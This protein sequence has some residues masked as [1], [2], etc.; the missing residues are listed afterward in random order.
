MLLIIVNTTLLNNSA[1]VNY[2]KKRYLF[3]IMLVCF[4]VISAVSAEKM[5][6]DTNSQDSSLSESVIEDVLYDGGSADNGTFSD[7]QKKIDGADEGSTILLENNYTYDFGF[8][9]DGVSINKTLTIN[10]NGYVIDALGQ[11]RIFNVNSASVTLNDIVFKN[12]NST[13]GGAVF[14]NSDNGIINNCNFTNSIATLM[15]G[16]IFWYGANGTVNNS[17]FI[18]NTAAKYSG[19]A[20]QWD[21]S[22]DNGTV[23]NC[24]FINN[25]ATQRGGAVY[26][27]RINGT[28][29]NSIFINSTSI[30][31]G[32]VNWSPNAFN[33][34]LNNS[35]FINNT[36]DDGG[37]IYWEGQNGRMN[38]CYFTN[39]TGTNGGA[40]NWQKRYGLINNCNFTGN[41]ATQ[42]G[43]AIFW[44]GTN[45]TVN[46][47]NFTN[48]GANNG[49]AVYWYAY[50]G[51]L[52]SSN[53]ANNTATQNG[54]AINWQGINGT[55]SICNFAGNTAQSN[56][57]A[58]SLDTVSAIS[59]DGL[60]SNIANYNIINSAFVDNIAFGAGSAVYR[61]GNSSVSIND[62]WW[63]SNS[64]DWN[65]L[66]GDSI[67][68][69]SSFAVL[70]AAANPQEI[71]TNTKSDLDYILYLNGTDGV[72]LIPTREI[73]LSST[74]G[75][76]DNTSG[77]LIGSEFS[78]EFT[79]DTSGVYEIIA[80]VDNEEIKIRIN[81]SEAPKKD[82][83]ITAIAEPVA[84][85]EN[86]T[87]IVTGFENATGNV[88]A[89]I[90]GGTCYAP[91]VD[92]TATFT[93]SDVTS[94]TTAYIIYEG[95][96]N[97]NPANTM[98]D[99]TVIPKS[100]VNIVADNLT[101]YY[102]GP[103][104]F[105]ANVY[106]CELNPI[107][108]KSVNITINGVTY[109]KITDSNGTAYLNIRLGSGT[110]D[111]TVKVDNTTVKSS[112]TVLST[113]IGGDITKYYKNATQYAVQV[114]DTTG[115]A[116]G[117]GEVVT[118]NVNGVFYNRTTDANGIAAL[119][120]NLPPGDYVITAD[121]K[122]CKVSNNITVLPVLKAEDLKMKYMDGSQFKV[123]LVDGQGNPYA[124][125]YVKFNVNGKLYDKLTDG[126]G[127]TALNIRLPSGEYIIT[128]SYNGANIANRI[129]IT[130]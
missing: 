60:I 127:Q 101:K 90:D 30:S 114:Y 16:A 37:A 27:E 65:D 49:G 94:N 48:N 10:G 87:I 67:A 24:I 85:G 95:D 103:E 88:T 128:S 119:N 118:F 26:W 58:I 97:Y 23:D 6:N 102:G 112:V 70:N 99:I 83:N 8:S 57:G 68:S 46:S 13:K 121:Y 69:P 86:I 53:F 116:S 73:K 100:D 51:T 59:G 17:T 84:A 4:F 44:E 105:V 91:I 89:R 109:T 33:G 36:G 7:L 111:V 5:E 81:V 39:N 3:L 54:G 14:W 35:S 9:T 78:T 45:G 92:G 41:T 61:T 21:S 120:I 80:N 22:S 75:H 108:N 50:N 125:Q 104:R 66:T 123:N 28:I 72:A 63:A 43:G 15:G 76:L 130:G 1:G 71:T 18:N 106:D 62:N 124:G 25:T 82:L 2:L 110:Y 29:I 12:A 129:I 34:V 55:V 32:A 11:S 47:C 93:V 115:K 79:S 19:G 20:I 38:S 52:N 122:G 74:G 126:N 113:V 40:L 117:A 98:V 107:A 56:G 77:Y 42:N 96:N 31:G 64:P